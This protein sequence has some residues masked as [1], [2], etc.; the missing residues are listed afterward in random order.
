MV[1]DWETVDKI[2][3]GTNAEQNDA[4]DTLNKHIKEMNDEDEE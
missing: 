2:L 4:V 1:I 3:N